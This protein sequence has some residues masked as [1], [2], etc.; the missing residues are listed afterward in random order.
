MEAVNGDAVFALSDWVG[1]VGYVAPNLC[2]GSW[3]QAAAE[4]QC[5]WPLEAGLM[6]SPTFNG[7]SWF[8]CLVIAN[9]QLF[10]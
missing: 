6:S 10:Q 4:R 1:Y 3:T 2:Q 7:S 8:R 5:K 9:L